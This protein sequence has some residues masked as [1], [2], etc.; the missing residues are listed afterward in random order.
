MPAITPGNH[1]AAEVEITIVERMRDFARDDWDALLAPDDS[2]FL[3]WDWL[4]AMEES[5]SAARK[6]GWAPYHLA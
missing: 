3:E 1:S 2:P 6:T 5:K 4:A